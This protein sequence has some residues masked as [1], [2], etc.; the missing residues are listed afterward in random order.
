MQYGKKLNRP[1]HGSA[2]LVK[3]RPLS[4]LDDMSPRGQAANNPSRRPAAPKEG[5]RGAVN[6]K[7]LRWGPFR[8]WYIRRTLKFIDRSK[9]KGRRLPAGLAETA[10]QLGRVPKERRAEVLEESI[11]AQRD[12]AGTAREFRRAADRQR[13]ST[14]SDTRYRPGRPPGAGKQTRTRPR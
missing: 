8:R 2:D 10:R 13:L 9:A 3:A 14:R 11:L 5:V 6:Q 4:S 7:L 12:M 1:A